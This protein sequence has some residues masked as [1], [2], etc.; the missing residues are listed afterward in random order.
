MSEA[1]GI[2]PVMR[3]PGGT[4][5]ILNVDD[6][7]GGRYAVSRILERAGY[8]VVEAGS[9][10][11]LDRVLAEGPRPDLIVL[12]VNLP[13]TNGLEIAR[14]LKSDPASRL[15]PILH[16]SA[17]YVDAEAH[18]LGLDFGADAYLAQPIEPPVLLA[19]IRA[20]L[21]AQ[22]AERDT[23]AAG[24]Q[25][26]STFDAV[27]DPVAILDAEGC[28][29]RA[30]RAMVELVGLPP[31]EVAGTPI[32]EALAR[33]ADPDLRPLGAPAVE[34]VLRSGEAATGE[35]RLGERVFQVRLDPLHDADGAVSGAVQTMV[36]VS[37]SRAAE[38]Q[39]RK[40]LATRRSIFEASP[41]AIVIFDAE[42]R[43]DAWSPAAEALFGW[44]AEEVI[45]RPYP[46]VTPE[47]EAELAHEL[48]R[49]LGG[50]GF[51]EFETWRRRKD[52]SRVDVAVWAAPLDDGHGGIRGA[53]HILADITQRQRSERA[54]RFL[55][56]ASTLLAASLDPSE[57][58]ARLADLVVPDIAD[59]C[60][61]DV[62]ADDGTLSRIG[63]A[64]RDPARRNLLLEIQARFPASRDRPGIR[65][66][67]LR[68]GRSRLVGPGEL[69]ERLRDREPEHRAL[70][71]RLGV[72]SGIWVPL[73]ARG[74]LL[75][76]ISLGRA[77]AARP[78]DDADL[79]L[80]E[81]L[82][83]RAAVALDN[84]DL[85]RA[86][87]LARAA[88]EQSAERIGRLQ[89]Q[90]SAFSRS[91]TPA[92]VAQAIVDEGTAA[93]GAYAGL[94]MSLDASAGVL[95][96]LRATGY[97]EELVRRYRRLP[98]SFDAPLTR[99]ATTGQPVFLSKREELAAGTGESRDDVQ[100]ET[101][102]IAVLP[103]AVGTE[104]LGVLGLSFR[105][106]RGFEE[107]DREFLG[108]LARLAAQALERAR[109]FEAER[110][111]RDSAQLAA[112]RLTR[113]QAATAAFS[114]AATQDDVVEVALEHGLR[115]TGAYRGLLARVSDDG[116]R[117]ELVRGAGF[118]PDELDPLRT[119][120][121]EGD[122]PLA[123]VARTGEP[124]WWP[125]EASL[126]AGMGPTARVGAGTR[127]AA[128]LPLRFEGRPIGL[129]YLGF[130]APTEMS[131]A[132]RESLET[133]AGLTAQALERARLF[134]AERRARTT[135]QEARRRLAHLARAER[136]RAA[137]LNAVIRA[138]GDA[139]LVCDPFGRTLLANP[140]ANE[141]LA[142]LPVT[143]LDELLGRLAGPDGSP[144]TEADLRAGSAREARLAGADERW[145]EVRLYPVAGPGGDDGVDGTPRDAADDAETPS[146]IVVMR[147][148]T[149]VRRAKAMREAFIGVLSHELRTPIT[150]IYAGTKVLSRPGDRIPEG[151]RREVFRDLEAESERLYRLVEDLLVL[152]RVEAGTI[153]VA[154]EPVLLQHILPEVVR[155]EGARWPDTTLRAEVPGSLP[156]VMAERTYVEQV[157]RNLLANAAKYGPPG[158]TVELAAE[159]VEDEVLVRVLD[160]GPGFP[161]DEADRLFEL[162]YRSPK[163]AAQVAGA[164]IGL[165]VS[166]QLVEAM[167]GRIWAR[168]RPAGGAEFG[169]SLR[170][171]EG[172]E[173]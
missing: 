42:G 47:K 110:E 69:A 109:L 112:E 126:R 66:D 173:A 62:L 128:S 98:L 91:L 29:L 88:A 121:L 99:A 15:I 24:Q 87:W 108:A 34:G 7:P 114:G 146:V 27:G 81:E 105:E 132:E 23:T 61:V 32:D 73:T 53:I 10:A 89:A 46:A 11:E 161:S 41:L 59:W 156:A 44:P 19:T 68:T 57:T 64:H 118:G 22:Q 51:A 9:G 115:L 113:L 21:R 86:E 117:L 137:E 162:F 168:P 14:R 40:L 133:L 54:L 158:S 37:A 153:D 97:H 31:A 152:S 80:A 25:W 103:L 75:G 33:V 1:V 13:D 119:V 106:P 84:A 5:R 164:G 104:V 155:T 170:V 127:A 135:A 149:A 141:L 157:A 12:D 35:L 77:D 150:T 17:T 116:Q 96:L 145:L 165:F 8:E 72:E 143:S 6:D 139:V 160:E 82:G 4:G 147:D 20:L 102:A 18:A 93:L 79:A 111:A 159:C 142:D 48:A 125:D 122:H 138:M 71:R 30:N 92:Q 151:T 78:F 58:M 83:R 74:R 63:A 43:V 52:G 26:Q 85:Y 28:I 36:D 123:V 94:L 129:L 65:S 2:R 167:G 171:L 131:E 70:I 56:E 16:L 38:L 60:A 107:A 49:N 100:P 148:V 95:A 76:V 124:G 39:M 166:R 140:A 169:F 3:L 90:T 136:S 144:L 172:D 163:T 134:E 130:D 120:P 154:G 101:G 55:A 45:G 50:E 67:V